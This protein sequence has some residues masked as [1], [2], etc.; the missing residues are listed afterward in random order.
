MDS[1]VWLKFIPSASHIRIYFPIQ[2]V[3]T[4]LLQL[5]TGNDCNALVLLD[6]DSITHSAE[7]SDSYERSGLTAGQQYWLKFSGSSNFSFCI[8][9]FSPPACPPLPPCSYIYNGS[10]ETA[11]LPNFTGQL[12]NASCW[13]LGPGGGTC[14]GSSSAGGNTPDLFA[15]PTTNFPGNCADGNANIGVPGNFDTPNTP[16]YAGGNYMGLFKGEKVS[17]DV[18]PLT[19]SVYILQFASNTG[20][21]NSCGYISD[22]CIDLTTTTGAPS[23]NV[24][25]PCGLGQSTQWTQ[26]TFCV[27]LQNDPNA[28]LYNRLAIMAGSG[29]ANPIRPESLFDDFSLVKLSDAGPDKTYCSCSTTTLGPGTCQIPGATYLWSPS[30]GLSCTTCP[31]PIVNLTNCSAAPVQVVYTV[32]V[33][34]PSQTCFAADQ[35]TVTVNPNTCTPAGQPQTICPGGSVTLGDPCN[36]T[37]QSF[38]NFTWSPASGLSNV[39]RPNPV[40]SPSVTTNYSI[41]VTN[42]YGCTSSGQVA[43]TVLPAPTV[44]AGPDQS[45]CPGDCVTLTA[46]AGGT[47]PHTYTW[48]DPSGIICGPGLSPFCFPCP[49]STTN[50]TVTVTDAS[51]CTSSDVVTVFMV[52]PPIASFSFTTNEDCMNRPFTFINQSTGANSFT[53]DFGDGTVLTN[54]AAP[55]THTYLQPGQYVVILTAGNTNSN[56]C[57]VFSALVSVTPTSLSPSYNPNCCSYTYTYSFSN[58]AIGTSTTF[59]GA[60][61]S[62]KDIM[63]ISGNST[64]TFNNCTVEFGPWGKVIVEPG[65]T[66]I[67]NGTKFT[68]LQTCGTMWQGI[69]VWGNPSVSH[70]GVANQAQQGKLV[71]R[72]TPTNVTIIERA[73]NAVTLGK[74]PDPFLPGQCNQSAPNSICVKGQYDVCYSGGIL[75]AAPGTVATKPTFQDN[76]HNIRVAPYKFPNVSSIFNCLF[77][78]NILPDPGYRNLTVN[79]QYPNIRNSNY[80]FANMQGRT[81]R[82]GYILK[83]QWTGVTT[84]LRNDFN[85]AS[86]IGSEMGIEIVDGKCNINTNWFRNM[87]RGIFNLSTTSTPFL[88]NKII[89]NIFSNTLIQTSAPPP[90][91]VGIYSLGSMAD[92]IQLNTFGNIN[93]PL[94][95]SKNRFGIYLNNSSGFSIWD[96]RF[97]LLQFGLRSINSGI[98][99]GVVQKFSGPGP[100][101]DF[102]R[103]RINIQTDLNN[104]NLKIKCNTQD[105]PVASEYGVNWNNPFSNY[106]L[107]NQGLP[108]S[109]NINPAGNRFDFP[110]TFNHPIVKKEIRSLY[111]YTYFHHPNPTEF[112]PFNAPGSIVNTI[113][114]TAPSCNNFEQCCPKDPCAPPAAPSCRIGQIGSID[115]Q[116]NQL[117]TEFNA[118]LANLDNGQTAQLIAA[119]NQDTPDGQLKNMLRNASPLSDEVLQN[120]INRSFVTSPGTFKQVIIPNSP[121]SAD[122]LP[123]LETKLESLPQGIAAEITEAQGSVAYRTLSAIS[124][125]LSAWSV[126]RNYQVNQLLSFYVEN[127]SASAINL[128][129]EQNTFDAKAQLLATFIAFGNL[130]AAQAEL[131]G[132]T[133]ASVEEQALLDL[134]GL[135]L[136]LEMQGKSVFEMDFTQQQLVRNIAESVPSLAQANACAILHLVFNEDCLE[137]PDDARM[138]SQEAG[139][140]KNVNTADDYLGE[141]IPNPFNHTTLVLYTL[142]EE[143]SN[144]SIVIYDLA[145]KRIKSYEVSAGRG[146]LEIA[147]GEFDNGVYFYKLEYAGMVF[148]S[149]KMIIIK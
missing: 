149:K 73:H 125:E 22:V 101:N 55:I 17:V 86:D 43:V 142:P 36:Q 103:C 91:T 29:T 129:R 123:A 42:S 95:Q 51:G 92:I 45:I 33:T 119:I 40:A 138:Q 110:V 12:T 48:Q 38:S 16:A 94:S 141:N 26:E 104:S 47:G 132:M 65:S 84:F 87:N 46:T 76:A 134:Q 31:N 146:R 85:L 72:N 133:A 74:F 135:I 60:V 49:T 61:F 80:A 30:N 128:L 127:D 75:D 97:F 63:T 23:Y 64:V 83:A 44:N 67:L 115:Q 109:A 18:A 120:F 4:G 70:A 2:S 34:D 11:T 15:G 99:G 131:A 130:S 10:F 106:V 27:D 21:L 32:T 122:V 90:G 137:L 39:N 69:E 126:E 3:L 52:P 100:G 96:N 117:Q 71:V 102:R 20:D 113:Q 68:G 37:V 107:A 144:A 41:S 111:K 145:G 25:L 58:A 114:T 24:C 112:R 7:N 66:L 105:N 62:V 19:N 13:Y 81:Y 140:E 136:N 28:G 147:A 88:G 1:T 148:G 6:K 118:I 35:V 89:N 139:Q 79:Y 82:F 53:I 143:I 98:G 78:G 14:G 57:D 121:I 59:N 50:Y 9:H 8:D 124:R 77:R 5:Y 108:G 116:I 56:C 93:D 54:P